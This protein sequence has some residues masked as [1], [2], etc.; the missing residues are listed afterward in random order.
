MLPAETTAVMLGDGELRPAV[1]E[2]LQTLGLT[3]QS[4]S[5]HEAV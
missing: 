1:E 4:L 3:G 5:D 2:R